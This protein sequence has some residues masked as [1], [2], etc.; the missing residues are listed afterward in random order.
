VETKNTRRVSV[1]N[2]LQSSEIGDRIVRVAEKI[3]LRSGFS[4][5]LMDDLAREL[6]M[7]KKTL[8]AHFASKEALLHAVLIQRVSEVDQG[9][10]SIV[11]A[12]ESF[13]AKMG[14][15]ARFLQANLAEVSPVFLEDIR[16]YAP[17]CFRVVEEFRGRAI[18]RYFGRLFDEGFRAGHVRPQVHRDI[19]IRM[20]V[21]SIQG[22]IR[23]EAVSELHLHPREALE[24][25]LSITFD[26]ILTPKGRKARRPA[27]RRPVRQV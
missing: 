17:D 20:L 24:H 26:G 11:S 27:A 10:E 23:P 25:I 7:S 14:H 18:P 12:K 13:P 8:Y 15:V 9:L 5:V 22:I 2:T 4:R 3:F 16:R 19:L 6:G 1:V 21:L